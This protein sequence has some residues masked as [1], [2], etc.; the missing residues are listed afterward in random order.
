[1][2]VTESSYINRLNKIYSIRTNILLD[3]L[4]LVVTTFKLKAFESDNDNTPIIYGFAYSQ[5]EIPLYLCCG[6]S[7]NSR[8]G[9]YR[10]H[11]I[12]INALNDIKGQYGDLWEDLT[13][14]LLAKKDAANW[15]IYTDHFTSHDK[16]KN[17]DK[18]EQQIIKSNLHHNILILTWF[19]ELFNFYNGFKDVHETDSLKVKEDF[20]FMKSLIAEYE[21]SVYNLKQSICFDD[22]NAKVGQ[23]LIPLSLLEATNAFSIEYKPWREYAFSMLFNNFVVNKITPGFPFMGNFTFIKMQNAK[24]VPFDNKTQILRLEL[25][26][27]TQIIRDKLREIAATTNA[28][29]AGIESS[30][31]EILAEK[32]KILEKI[33]ND[34]TRFTEKE[35]IMSQYTIILT[36]EYVGKT[37]K[38]SLI[39]AKQ[40]DEFNAQIGDIRKSH[41]TFCR[42]IFE[43]IYNLLVMNLHA[44]AMHTDLHINNLTLN[45]LQDS[46]K[47]VRFIL[48]NGL[49]SADKNVCFCF[50]TTSFHVCLIDNSR[51]I[52]SLDDINSLKHGKCK[53]IEDLLA[54][55]VLRLQNLYSV[56]LPEFYSNNKILVDIMLFTNFNTFFPLLT[57]FDALQFSTICIMYFMKKKL[58]FD[59]N[60]MDKNIKLLKKI[61]EIAKYNLTTKFIE[62]AKQIQTIHKV[63][64]EKVKSV[65]TTGTHYSSK[66]KLKSVRISPKLIE[67]E[68][69]NYPNVQILKLF[70]RFADLNGENMNKGEDSETYNFSN[71]LHYST[72]KHTSLSSLHLDNYDESNGMK[73]DA[74]LKNTIALLTTQFSS[75]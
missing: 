69:K 53:N 63:T 4:K 24:S 23:K 30:T 35:L 42:Y 15:I 61:Q 51:I 38:N 36:S 17:F 59:K 11:F 10:P 21:T 47:F 16:I 19:N 65:K 72:D 67:T 13:E 9:E 49:F 33:T 60:T 55:S 52:L 6:L 71:L 7:Y 22:T 25:S 45:N 20:D 41:D 68:H 18:T 32:M 26:Q 39:S 40:N 62:Y 57:A 34:A 70:L 73:S 46:S 66:N 12:S 44:K 1:M 56:Y 58:K 48:P 37:W 29:F 50:P 28:Q 75:L 5:D 54:Y 74:S 2:S 64:D 27:T 43:V 3:A 31:A 14:Y 8:D